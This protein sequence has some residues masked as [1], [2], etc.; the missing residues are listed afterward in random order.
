MLNR[1]KIYG[2]SLAISFVSVFL[3][4]QSS[5]AQPYACLPTCDAGDA[6][7]FV[8]AGPNLSSFIETRYLFG[9][10]SPN[11]S[12]N[13]EIGIFD[14]D[15]GTSQGAMF[16]DWDEG[17]GTIRVT[18]FADPLGEGAVTTQLGQWSGD[19]SFGNN[20]GNPMPDNGWFNFVVTNAEAARSE[21]GN[22]RYTLV[23]DS[24]NNVP[25]ARN[26]YKI[27]TDGSMIILPFEEF[28]FMSLP[29][30]LEDQLTVWPN[31]VFPGDFNNPA[32]FDQMLGQFA[33][34]MQ[35]PTC[36]TFGGPY[37]GGFKFFIDVE[38]GQDG[39]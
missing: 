13:L 36:C 32:C 37:D 14:G 38:E 23:V 9:I 18:L 19:G 11:D 29:V 4:S 26:Q 12:P 21:N 5:F 2:L 15:D 22:F 16:S 8:F 35:D 28:A 7:F 20:I 3:I 33:C 39:F 30:T 34:Q 1:I 6:R 27:R 17:L 25:N 10:S 24:L 31:V